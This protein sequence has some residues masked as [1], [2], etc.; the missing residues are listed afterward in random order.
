MRGSVGQKPKCQSQ[1]AECN[2]QSQQPTAIAMPT[3]KSRLQSNRSNFRH[4]N[5]PRTGRWFASIAV[6]R[7]HL[8]FG[9]LVD[10]DVHRCPSFSH[11]WG[12]RSDQ[13]VLCFAGCLVLA[14]LGEHEGSLPFWSISNSIGSSLSVGFLDIGGYSASPNFARHFDR[15]L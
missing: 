9:V 4:L 14:I 11:E 6:R 10:F 13:M 3:A 15:F 8:Q 7:G 12:F 5:L 1:I 2:S